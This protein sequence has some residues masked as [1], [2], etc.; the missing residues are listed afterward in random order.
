MPRRRVAGKRKILPDPK[1]RS[2]LLNKFINILM[3]SG[4]KSVAESVVYGALDDLEIQF[5]TYIK[6]PKKEDPNKHKVPVDFLT[7]K[8]EKI[9]L[10][11]AIIDT[12]KPSVE[13]RSRRVGG[14]TYQVPVEVKKD[15]AVALAMRWLVIAARTRSE[16]GMMKCLSSEMMQI[17]DGKGNA[18]KK[19]EDTHKMA[20]ANQAFAHFRWWN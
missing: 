3:L 11:N 17:I 6:T 19:R 18:M 13:V 2:V 8:S 16:K 5:Q 9:E 20:K 10:F 7:S 14:S 4:K 12:V 1:Y 15:R